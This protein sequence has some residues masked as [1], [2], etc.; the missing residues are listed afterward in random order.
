G[1]GSAWSSTVGE[2]IRAAVHHG[3]PALREIAD[4]HHGPTVDEVI[5]RPCRKR[6]WSM[7]RAVVGVAHARHRKAVDERVR[8]AG[9]DHTAVRARVA[10]PTDLRHQ[11]L[12][13]T[14]ALTMRM[15]C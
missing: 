9:G 1:C 4:P 11:G 3:R 13:S 2:M 10:D 6:V 8:A 5:R 7:D 14:R 12:M 15:F